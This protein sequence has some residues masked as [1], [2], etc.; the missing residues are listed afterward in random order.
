M[1]AIGQETAV[2][3]DFSQLEALKAE[4]QANPNAA[5]EEVA[6][7]FESLF[8]HMMLKSMREATIKSDLFGSD[9]M[10]AYQSMA[11]QQTALSLS[12]QGGVGL[13]RVLVEQMQVRGQVPGES[14][15]NPANSAVT[16]DDG[17]SSHQTAPVMSLTKPVDPT[18]AFELP[19]ANHRAIDLKG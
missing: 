15:I 4:A 5:L 13:A 2:Y 11:D 17:G 18:K 16:A 9:Q 1:N 7:Q 8:L 10:E 6:K 3:T 12:Q 14:E 19:V